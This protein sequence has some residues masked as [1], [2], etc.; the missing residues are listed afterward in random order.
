MGG[1][2]CDA[3][4]VVDSVDGVE[5]G[6]GP[7]VALLGER[8]GDDFLGGRG[9]HLLEPRVH[10][11]VLGGALEQRLGGHVEGLLGHVHGL[12][13]HVDQVLLGLLLPLPVEATGA[14]VVQVLEPLEVRGRHAA[15]VAQDVGQELAP[16]G[17]Q[18]LLGADGGGP[19]GRL[20]DQL[21]LELAR[22]E[23]V[24][25]LLEGGGDEEVAALGGAY[26]FL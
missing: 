22:V 9:H 1:G 7:Q 25:G 6:G 14:H 15:R 19:V 18:D 26:A 17:Q 12:A 2:S 10:D 5:V 16:L 21:G 23:L 4:E 11:V 3:V 20:H 13:H 8:G 24:D